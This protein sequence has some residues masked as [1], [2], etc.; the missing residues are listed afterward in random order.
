[1]AAAAARRLCARRYLRGHSRLES[2]ALHRRAVEK[3][4]ETLPRPS[5]CGAAALRVGHAFTPS[6][7]VS[8]WCD[9]SKR[10]LKC[11]RRSSVR[12]TPLV[13]T[14]R[15][16]FAPSPVGRKTPTTD[17]RASRRLMREE[18]RL[19]RLQDEGI[20]DIISSSIVTT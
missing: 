4:P 19:S 20:T 2:C 12:S 1:M 14:V 9:V 3:R 15:R 17:A 18:A 5:S 16:L 8:E 10:I 6:R 7:S 11:L 13:L